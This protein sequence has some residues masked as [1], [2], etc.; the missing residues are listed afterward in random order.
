[1]LNQ[2]EIRQQVL[3]TVNQMMERWLSKEYTLKQWVVQ[4]FPTGEREKIADDF[5]MLIRANGEKWSNI[6][7]KM[8]LQFLMQEKS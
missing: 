5:R 3:Q 7:A 4:L 1:M 8:L 6:G 2:S